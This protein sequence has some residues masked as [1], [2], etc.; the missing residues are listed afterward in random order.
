M[1][2]ECEILMQHALAG[3][4]S[5]PASRFPSPRRNIRGA[6]RISRRPIGWPAPNIRSSKGGNSLE[7]GRHPMNI[8]NR[9]Y[10][11]ETALGVTGG[12]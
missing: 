12:S 9:L 6:N 2:D 1:D 4:R 8:D 10:K 5:D 11:I 3:D 7:E